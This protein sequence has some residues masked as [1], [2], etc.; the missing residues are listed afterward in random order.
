MAAR[1][2]SRNMWSGDMGTLCSCPDRVALDR[3][4]LNFVRL[5]EVCYK[6]ELC[7]YQLSLRTVTALTLKEKSKRLG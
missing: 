7:K 1:S 3:S 4:G 5:C 6:F 2:I